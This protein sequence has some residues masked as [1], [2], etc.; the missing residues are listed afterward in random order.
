MSSGNGSGNG[1]GNGKERGSW[2]SFPDILIDPT[3]GRMDEKPVLPG[4]NGRPFRGPVPN[5]RAD[6]PEHRQP[7]EA[8]RVHVE[9]LDLSKPADLGKYQELSQMVA[10]GFAMI[11]FEK[12]EYDPAKKNWRVLVRWFEI[13]AY[14]PQAVSRGIVD[15]YPR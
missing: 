13:F 2:G 7:Q 6:D 4:W 14:M 3:G 12:Q 15:G 5:L 1:N 11:S 8:A 10:N 9:V